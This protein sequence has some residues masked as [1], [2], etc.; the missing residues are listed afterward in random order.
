MVSG[1]T[2]RSGESM[3]PSFVK[4]ISQRET[5]F[6]ETYFGETQPTDSA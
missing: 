2:E 1:A 4:I 3:S 6:G 5:F